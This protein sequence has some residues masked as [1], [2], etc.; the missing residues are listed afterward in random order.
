MEEAL[1]LKE[2]KAILDESKKRGISVFVIG[3]FCVKAYDSL[4]RESHDL[5]FAVN[6]E[7]FDLLAQL[8]KAVRLTPFGIFGYN[9][10]F[11]RSQKQKCSTKS[12]NC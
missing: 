2:L 6:G 3:A 11:P 12:T 7:S 10:C 1:L 5:D 4:I 8:L 9:D